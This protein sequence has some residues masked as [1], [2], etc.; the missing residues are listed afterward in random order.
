MDAERNNPLADSIGIVI[1]DNAALRH[2]MAEQVLRLGQRQI[3]YLK[4]GLHQG[5]AAF[6]LVAADGIPV[7]MLESTEGVARAAMHLRLD[8]VAV[9]RHQDNLTVPWP[10]LLRRYAEQA[11]D[12]GI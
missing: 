9:H 6:I 10:Q 12:C 5:E 11:G 3:A 7:V 2:I 8:L 4:T 1:P